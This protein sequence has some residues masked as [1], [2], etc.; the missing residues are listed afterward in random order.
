M[1]EKFTISELMTLMKTIRERISSLKGLRSEVS[2]ETKNKWRVS[3][4]IASEVIPKFDVKI[5]DKKIME[6]ENFLFR[7]D[8][9]IKIV[10]SK[11]VVDYEVD[12]EKLL[13]PLD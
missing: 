9:K 6:L 10:N 11:T 3:S 12:V 2:T 5:V 1:P 4:E 8:S 13:N 7:A